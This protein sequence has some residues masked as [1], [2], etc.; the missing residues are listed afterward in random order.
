MKN[1]NEKGAAMR[2]RKCKLVGLVIA[3]I[4][5]LGCHSIRYSSLVGKVRKVLVL[6]PGTESISG[7]LTNRKTGEPAEGVRVTVLTKGEPLVL[8]SDADGIVKLPIR[9][10]LEAENP[11][12][13]IEKKYKG[14]LTVQ[15]G[16]RGH[17]WGFASSQLILVNAD[18]R[19]K[20]DGEGYS[21]WYSPGMEAQAERASKWLSHAREVIIG[22]SGLEPAAYGVVLLPEEKEGTMHA[23][24]LFGFGAPTFGFN[25]DQVDSP[26]FKDI[27]VHKWTKTTLGD[28]LDFDGNDAANG[29]VIDGLAEYT[30]FIATGEYRSNLKLIEDM[31]AYGTSHVNLLKRFRHMRGDSIDEMFEKQGF[32]PGYPLSFVFWY[33][34]CEAYGEDLPARFVAEMKPLEKRDTK[35]AIT[36]LEK[37]TGRKDIR[38]QLENAD[39]AKAID[40]LK[41]VRPAEEP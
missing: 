28:R 6:P 8:V 5:A 10:D 1:L 41:A 9:D 33:N 3:A 23:I 11:R 12:I 22:V 27:N 35:A 17:G 26:A 30:A 39:V 37:L 16:A 19:E 31:L 21:I 38:R 14:K 40:T 4:L 15:F 18:G 36:V 34:L 7:R 2:T 25:P 13:R 20:I 32:P 29:F 24:S